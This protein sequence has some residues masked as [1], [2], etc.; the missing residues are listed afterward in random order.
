MFLGAGFSVSSGLPLGNKLRDEALGEFLNSDGSSSHSQ[1]A[2]QFLN[3]IRDHRRFASQDEEEITVEE[4]RESLTLERVLREELHRH[5]DSATSPT[6]LALGQRND[7]V[8]GSPEMA[9]RELYKIIKH[10]R[11]SL[12]LVT[13]NFDTLVE[14]G[15][16]VEVFASE[17]D[18][19]RFS[20][21][22]KQYREKG[23]SVPLL[24][25]HGTLQDL[26]TVVVTVD[27]TAEG[28]A[29]SKVRALREL[30]D[31][32][33]PVQWAYIGYSARDP[34]VT[35]ILGLA[36]FREGIEESWVSPFPDPSARHF[37]DGHRP[38]PGRTFWQRSITETADEFMRQLSSIW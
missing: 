28:L 17:R 34:D 8:V 10:N 31:P 29:T 33:Q 21:Y 13:V 37:F 14:A 36:E 12:V 26:D 27:Q 19:D 22:L 20:S 32:N 16:G 23:G 2:E 38:N 4:F 3:Y 25:L 18:F 1:L 5:R 35:G 11:S 6:L 9:V 24:K 30:I 15:G 7:E